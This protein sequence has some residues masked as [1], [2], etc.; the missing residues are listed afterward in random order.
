MVE[1]AVSKDIVLKRLKRAEG[2]IRGIQRMIENG[3]EC[4]SVITQLAAVRSAI[5]GVAGLILK[6]Y[7]RICFEGETVRECV[8][9][10]SLARAIAIWGR[11][12]VGD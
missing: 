6:N 1:E 4:E 7:M 8:D 3:R 2:Q 12:H 9:I 11:V 10:E 5:E